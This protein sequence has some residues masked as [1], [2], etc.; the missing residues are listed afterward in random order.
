MGCPVSAVAG[1]WAG[2]RLARSSLLCR[3]PTHTL[4]SADDHS[5]VRLALLDGK[6]HSDYINASFIPV[7]LP[8][9]WLWHPSSG[10]CVFR[11]GPAGGG[12]GLL[13]LRPSKEQ[14]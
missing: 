8:A 11:I 2:L 6:P 12:A 9:G 5:R 4:P 1:W 3:L 14:V 13:G 10:V 7:G